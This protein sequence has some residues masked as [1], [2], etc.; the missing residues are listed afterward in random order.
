MNFRWLIVLIV[1]AW[2]VHTSTGAVEEVQVTP[3]NTSGFQVGELSVYQYLILIMTFLKIVIMYAMGI[4][5]IEVDL[6]GLLETGT[7]S[8]ALNHTSSSGGSHERKDCSSSGAENNTTSSLSSNGSGSLSNTTSSLSI[9]R[10]GFPDLV[11]TEY[12]SYV[13]YEGEFEEN[14]RR[15]RHLISSNATFN[16]SDSHSWRTLS[17]DDQ[18]TVAIARSVNSYYTSYD[19]R[20]KKVWIGF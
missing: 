17:K 6:G 20:P 4:L 7:I 18:D 12:S 13:N 1:T 19:D 2:N 15:G 9:E 10:M 16:K 14:V 8:G 5:P 11:T 3:S